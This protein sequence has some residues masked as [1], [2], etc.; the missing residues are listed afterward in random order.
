MACVRD[1]VKRHDP[2]LVIFSHGWLGAQ[3]LRTL[4]EYLEAFREIG[5]AQWVARNA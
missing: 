4:P 2:Q 5:L 3:Y 1:A